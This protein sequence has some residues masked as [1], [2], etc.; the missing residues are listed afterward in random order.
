M[1]DVAPKNVTVVPTAK[2]M[3]VLV[4][5]RIEA[6]RRHEKMN[7]TMVRIPAPDEYSMPSTVEIRSS[8]RFGDPGDQCRQLCTLTGFAERPKQIT[9]RNTGE[10]RTYIKVNHYLNL[11]E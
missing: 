6:V 4:V 1:T 2:P 3:Q 9:D 8:T 5:G 11:V 7:Y 10:Q